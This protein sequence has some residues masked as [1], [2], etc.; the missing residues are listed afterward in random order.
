MPSLRS[1]SAVVS[2]KPGQ[3]MIA[4]WE[5]LAILR[6]GIT[7]CD[8][9]IAPGQFML[10]ATVERFQMPNDLMGIVVAN[11]SKSTRSG[12]SAGPSERH[13]LTLSGHLRL[14]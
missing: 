11:G 12:R 3:P 4:A 9:V 8:A 7:C 5:R 14:Q 2:L 13:S 6:R 1:S 10:A